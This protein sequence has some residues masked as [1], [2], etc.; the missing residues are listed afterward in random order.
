MLMS[1][2]LQNNAFRTRAVFDPVSLLSCERRSQV[3][4]AEVALSFRVKYNSP[5]GDLIFSVSK[6]HII[7]VVRAA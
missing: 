2:R 7:N 1:H 6:D 3:L 5:D 4:L